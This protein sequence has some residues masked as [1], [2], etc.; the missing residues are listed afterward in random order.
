M[1]KSSYKK[2]N[3]G[4]AVIIVLIALIVVAAV[5]T[6]AYYFSPAPKEKTYTVSDA[7]GQTQTL[8]VEEL[9]SALDIQTF[10]PGITINGVDMSGKTKEQAAAFLAGD[11]TSDKPAVAINLDVDG[12]SYP[13]DKSA[14]TITSNLSSVID[15]AYN[16]NRTSTNTDEAAAL[17]ERYQTLVTLAQTPKNYTTEYSADTAQIDSAVHAILD[18]LEK[19]AVDAV[20]TSFDITKLSFVI[21]D[22]AEGRSFDT[23][24]AISDVKAAVNAQE[25]TKTISVNS[26]VI[27]PK[28]TKDT[29]TSTLGLVS[30]TTTRT[31]DIS[32]RNTNIDLVCK[33]IDGLVLQ[34][35]ASFNF[36]KFV[37]ERTA[38]K[39]YKEAGGIFDGTLRQELGGGI[40][41]A[42]GT[43]YH[44]VLAAD[45]QVDER[46]PHSWP[47]TYVD[48][49]T[50]ATVTWDGANFQFTNNT[51]YPVAIH[52]YYKDRTVTVSIYGRP[53]ADGMKI[54][55]V[56][57]VL[58]NTAP[59]PTEYVADPLTPA[60]T[61]TTIK[62][63]HNAI[64]AQCFKVYYKDGVEVKRVLASTSTY[65]AI[66]EKI[67]VGVL[68]PD[69]TL[70]TVDPV[71][72]VVNIPGVTP[73]VTPPAGTTPTATSAPTAPP[74]A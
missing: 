62:T 39:G 31:T 57:V 55:I 6:A 43:L 66:A 12:V 71:T 59:G 33:T 20:A 42:N 65:N 4:K 32:N 21:T 53:V 23:D 60:G 54:Q 41:Q 10:Y 7:G 47:S 64:S 70:Y 68:A 35:G 74:A 9:K 56:G 40:C 52:A 16:Y 27:E 19:D 8:T 51:N 72:G 2:K 15:E 58:S 13:L 48:T 28:V 37:G 5:G 44:S 45:L 11:P 38:E 17:V 69:G 25:Y 73:T 30:S 24:K 18:P 63:A 1:K 34:P 29:L 26:T 61:K 22:S 36:N 49:G 50:D 67:G 14:V 3:S 46:H